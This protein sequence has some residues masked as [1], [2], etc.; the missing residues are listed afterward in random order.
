MEG[1]DEAHVV[2]VYIQHID[3]DTYTYAKD[4]HQ[5]MGTAPSIG[6]QEAVMYAQYIYICTVL[7]LFEYN[8]ERGCEIR[9][10]YE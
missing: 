7:E 5:D 4:E 2:G 10:C 8:K 9:M 6:S 3:T 1:R